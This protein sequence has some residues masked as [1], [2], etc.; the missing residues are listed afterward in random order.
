MT[1]NLEINPLKLPTAF[2]SR[3][4]VIVTV[5]LSFSFLYGIRLGSL[6][7]APHEN[8]F[9]KGSVE[10]A[11]VLTLSFVLIAYIDYRTHP[12][13]GAA[14]LVAQQSLVADLFMRQLENLL[15][16]RVLS[17]LGSGLTIK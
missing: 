15:G 9:Y 6:F 16:K 2:A 13:R 4:F 1:R 10:I 12:I 3:A 8:D 5:C 11:L 17:S 7:F 14:H